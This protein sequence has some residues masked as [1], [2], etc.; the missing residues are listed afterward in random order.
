M[1]EIIVE[2]DET[3]NV[4]VE[5]KGFIGA[6][7]QKLTKELEAALGDV[8]SVKLKPE[9]RQQRTGTHKVGR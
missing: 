7:C 2:I 5:G 6:D 3:G 4:I 9:Y 1:E 8:Q